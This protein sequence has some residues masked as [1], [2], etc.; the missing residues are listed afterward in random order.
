MVLFSGLGVIAAGVT[1]FFAGLLVFVWSQQP[2][3]VS[4]ITTVPCALLSLFVGC[5][6]IPHQERGGRRNII[7]ILARKK[8]NW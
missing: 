7:E 6:F 3:L 5:L 8:G 2:R 4:I 1:L